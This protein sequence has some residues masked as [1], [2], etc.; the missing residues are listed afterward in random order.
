MSSLL[1]WYIFNRE[2]RPPFYPILILI[3]L[4]LV[5]GIFAEILDTE[6]ALFWP[7]YIS[8]IGFYAL[9][10]Y[11]GLYAARFRSSNR[12]DQVILAGRNLPLFIAV[13][14]MSATW[15]GE[16]ISTALLS[17]P[18]PTGLPGFKPPGGTP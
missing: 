5:V 17:T 1:D 18:C 10:F 6:R 15:V 12:P 11:V 2:H 4:L 9:I 16:V 14:T 3:G 8:M 13:F 7:G